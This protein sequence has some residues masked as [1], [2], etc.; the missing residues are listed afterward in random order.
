[1]EHSLLV[2]VNGIFSSEL[3]KLIDIPKGVEIGSIAEAIKNDNKIVK[4]HFGKYAENENFFFTTLSSA[5]TKDGAFV[6]VPDGKV[7]EDPI[8]II[9][10]TNSGNEKIITQPRNLFVAGKNSQVTIIEHFI[11][12]DDSDLLH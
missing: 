5:F 3:S 8:H 4:K 2:F 12:D 6:Y 10:L 7:V 11:S 9:F 1:M